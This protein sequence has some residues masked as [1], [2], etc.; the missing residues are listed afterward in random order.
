[1]CESV[2]KYPFSS[3]NRI[4]DVLPSA[5]QISCKSHGCFHQ[6]DF[7]HTHT[8]THTR[9]R[10]HIFKGKIPSS[11]QQDYTLGIAVCSMSGTM[12]LR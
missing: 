2:V 8:H 5:D 12:S 6:T 7:T 11:C 1:V 9:T 3:S 4:S 10:T